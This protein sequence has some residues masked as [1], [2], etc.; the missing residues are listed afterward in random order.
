MTLAGGRELGGDLGEPTPLVAVALGIVSGHPGKPSSTGGNRA[1]PRCFAGR[2][3]LAGELNTGVDSL[4]P[5]ERRVANLAA[6]GLSNAQIAARLFITVK[7]TEHHLAATYRK[8]GISSR[9]DLA[10]VLEDARA[11][12]EPTASAS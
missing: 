10:A 6:A 11:M 4:T 2:T 1:R 3:Q 7:T 8:L 12:P 5:S 9:N